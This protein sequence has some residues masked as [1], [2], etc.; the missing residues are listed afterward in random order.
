MN[1]SWFPIRGL[2]HVVELYIHISYIY[3][4]GVNG[5][6]RSPTIGIR[7]WLYFPFSPKPFFL[8]NTNKRS[9]ARGGLGTPLQTSFRRHLAPARDAA[10]GAITSALQALFAAPFQVHSIWG[11]G[12]IRASFSHRSGVVLAPL[13]TLFND[14]LRRW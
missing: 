7:A 11:S 3:V 14:I 10:Q 2:R 8:I 4:F 1:S 6:Y 13:M 9:I 12:A 5:K